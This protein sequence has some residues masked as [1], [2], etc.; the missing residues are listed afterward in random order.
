MILCYTCRPNGV[1]QPIVS[2]VGHIPN[3]SRTIETGS[4]PAVVRQDV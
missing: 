4:V 2:G 3:D 1:R